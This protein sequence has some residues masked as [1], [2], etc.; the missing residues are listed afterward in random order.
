MTT[1]QTVQLGKQEETNPY[2][3]NGISDNI[4]EEVVIQAISGALL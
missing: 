4:V 1:V 3:Y 2:D